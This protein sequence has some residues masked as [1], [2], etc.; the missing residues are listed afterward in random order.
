ME[1]RREYE[2][3]CKIIPGESE[4]NW[5]NAFEFCPVH[6]QRVRL[7]VMDIR[8]LRG[9]DRQHLLP[10]YHEEQCLTRQL[11]AERQIRIYR[12]QWPNFCQHCRGWG[13]FEWEEDPS[14]AG[15][16]LS[17]GTMTMSDPCHI[18]VENGKCPRCLSEFYMGGTICAVCEWEMEP[19]DGEIIP[20]EPRFYDCEGSCA[21]SQE[22]AERR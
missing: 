16:A 13:Y 20:G 3:G 12:A 15:V 22:H 11:T 14:P 10:F 7:R 1:I 17:P 5:R 19:E 18:C 9:T 6:E 2:C 8:G 4:D 21:F